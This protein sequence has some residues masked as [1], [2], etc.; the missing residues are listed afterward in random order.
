MQINLESTKRY[1]KNFM[2]HP[3]DCKKLMGIRGSRIEKRWRVI[4]VDK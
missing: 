1:T 3:L 4:Q 2:K